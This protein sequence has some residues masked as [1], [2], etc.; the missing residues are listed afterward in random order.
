[1]ATLQDIADKTG[2]SITTVSRVLSNDQSLSVTDKTRKKIYEVAAQLNYR[3]KIL[4][5]EVKNIV[6]L[7]WLSDVE[8]LEDIYFKTMRKNVEKIA[9]EYHVNLSVLKINEGITSVSKNTEGFIAVGSFLKEELDYLHA[10]T[11]NGVFLDSTPDSEY[12]SVRPDLVGT[13]KNAIKYLFEL[14]HEKIGFIGGTY[15]NPDTKENEP[16]IRER[17]FR[18]EM[19]RNGHLDEDFILTKRRFSIETGFQLMKQIIETRK[20]DMPTAF[21]VA[22]DPLAIGVLQALNQ[23]NISIPERVSVVGINNISVTKYVSPP[24]TTFAVDIPELSRLAVELLIERVLHNRHATKTI[25]LGT[26]LI[27]RAST[28]SI[29]E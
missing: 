10:I 25:Y 29:T 2:Y 26:E 5:P 9:N 7:Y 27:E 23:Y 22:A 3:R 21:F 11:P 24:L 19:H 4:R 13:T 6:F 17:T 15:F 8:E 20:K 28:F 16:D 1:M 18:E 12:D 14:G